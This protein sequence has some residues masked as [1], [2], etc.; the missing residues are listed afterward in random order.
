MKLNFQKNV[1]IVL[2][3]LLSLIF[4]SYY[5][6]ATN[7]KNKIEV[8]NYDNKTILLTVPKGYCIYDKKN[9]IEKDVIDIF[10]L[11]NNFTD[12]FAILFQECNERKNFLNNDDL[13]FRTFGRVSFPSLEYLNLIKENG[14]DIITDDY[15]KFSDNFNNHFDI[16]SLNKI[17]EEHTLENR[18]KNNFNILDNYTSLTS[19]QKLEFKYIYKD[20]FNDEYQK[21]I[22]Y[23]NK[24]IHSLVAL[25][26]EKYVID[27]LYYN[28]FKGTTLIFYTPLNISLCNISEDDNSIKDLLYLENV[29]KSYV[30]TLIKINSN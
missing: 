12:N 3:V 13:K 9:A 25:Y 26:Y 17:A 2:L 29:L 16:N 28:C 4:L 19:K 5:R 7:F 30:K 8:V 24:V 22:I 1:I 23:D 27:N 6:Y 18:K 10:K 14:M 15:L 11:I 20:F 21:Y